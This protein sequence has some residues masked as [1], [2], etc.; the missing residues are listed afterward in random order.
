MRRVSLVILLSASGIAACN[1]NSKSPSDG[2]G[3]GGG[4]AA[5]CG[6]GTV[7]DST[8]SKCIAATAANKGTNIYSN[9]LILQWTYV[10]SKA[11][12]SDGG[13]LTVLDNGDGTLIPGFADS[14]PLYTGQSGRQIGG[15]KL[16]AANYVADPNGTNFSPPEALSTQY[17]IGDWKQCAGTVDVYKNPPSGKH[18]FIF[19]VSLTK[20]PPRSLFTVWLLFGTD[21]VYNDEVL[22]TPLGGLPAAIISDDNGNGYFERELDPAIWLKSAAAIQGFSHGGMGHVPDVAAHPMS[23]V[24]VNLL[25]HVGGQTN[26]NVTGMV[27]FCEHD[28]ANNCITPASPRLYLPG[29]LGEDAIPILTLNNPGTAKIAGQKDLSLS[30]LQPY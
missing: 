24:D 11:S 21:N 29:N 23:T 20:C 7:F 4:T 30:M 14:T 3:S 8:S 19:A 2:G 25:Y 26:G 27:A 12:T 16:L 18:T 6:T 15:N 28:A 13:A 10:A 17:T 9:P 5:A 1:N 22:G